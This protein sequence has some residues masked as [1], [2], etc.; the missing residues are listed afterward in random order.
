M[1]SMDYGV[2]LYKFMVNTHDSMW[3]YE[4]YYY[5]FVV[6]ISSALLTIDSDLVSAIKLL[7]W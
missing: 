6:E 1:F 5:T 7:E 4:K 3:H 2:W